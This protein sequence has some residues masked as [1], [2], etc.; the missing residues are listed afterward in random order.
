MIENGMELMNLKIANIVPVGNLN[1]TKDSSIHMCL[2][3]VARNNE[4]YAQFYRKV[5]ETSYVVLDNGE[6]EG[7]Q[8][9]FEELHEVMSYIN[10]SEV[11]IPDSLYDKNSTISKMKD[12]TSFLKT[13]CW[14]YKGKLMAVPQGYDGSE[15]V[16]CAKILADQGCIHTLGISKFMIQKEVNRRTFISHLLFSEGIQKEIH[17]LGLNSLDELRDLKDLDN[18]IR[19][20][21]TCYAALYAQN[22]KRIDSDVPCRSR[23]FMFA[24]KAGS[25]LLSENIAKLY[26][27]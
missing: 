20:L 25:K 22:K 15:Y 16:E 6:A 17:V 2:A 4:S 12:F 9:T 19:S 7:N 1:E 24:Y 5:A 3:H 11:V 10:P 8:L 13:K 23:T 14:K 26:K 21:D 18:S 27:I